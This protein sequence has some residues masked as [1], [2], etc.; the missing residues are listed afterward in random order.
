MNFCLA[1]K[2]RFIFPVL[3]CVL[4]T[5]SCNQVD[6]F[7]KSTTIP[8][9]QWDNKF[10]AEGSFIISDTTS[11]YNLYIVLRH[12]DAYKYSN[13]WLNVGLQAPGD[14]MY[15]QKLNL[16][17]SGD[18]EGWEGTGMNDIW[19]VRKLIN[20]QPRRFIKKGEYKF[21]ISQVMRDNPLAYVMSAGLR[22]HKVQ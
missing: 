13:I 15:Y 1:N 5:I 11:P 21:S 12:T 14:T 3:A 8:H 19:E 9:Y 4:F 2:A 10:K 17:L 7:E 20:G 22:I 18:A 6:V 16:T